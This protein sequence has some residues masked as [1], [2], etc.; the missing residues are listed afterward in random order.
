MG[1]GDGPSLVM[2][3][4]GKRLVD[5]AGYDTDYMIQGERMGRGDFLVN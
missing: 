3:M 4:R 2:A 5:C 1:Y